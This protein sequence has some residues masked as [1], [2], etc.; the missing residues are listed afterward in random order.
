VSAD[1][2]ASTTTSPTVATNAISAEDVA[3]QERVRR[4][5]QAGCASR[6]PQE[7]II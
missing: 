1:G 4:L 2:A 3:Q 7:D 5:S 6:S